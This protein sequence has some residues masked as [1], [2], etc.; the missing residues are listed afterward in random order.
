M[1]GVD[2]YQA[3]PDD[4]EH[5]NTPATRR[6]R[7]GHRRRQRPDLP[8]RPL[9]RRGDD[10]HAHGDL[11]R[12][13]R[14]PLRLLGRRRLRG[15]R[16]GQLLGLRPDATSTTRS[17][18]TATRATPGTQPFRSDA[19]G[20]GGHKW[21]VDDAG[22]ATHTG[23]GGSYI[24]DVRDPLHPREVANTGAAGDSA[25]EGSVNHY[26]DFIH[27]NSFRP[28]APGV[29]R[30]CAPV[31]GQRQHP[32]RHR[33]GLRGPRLLDRRVVPDLARQA[34]RRL[35]RLD[36]AAGQ[37]GARRPRHLPGPG[38]ARSAPR[39]G[40]TTTP[41]ASSRSASTAAAPS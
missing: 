30:R 25:R 3:S 37:G 19:V 38:R 41:A 29:P 23:A 5:V 34:P 13:H 7:A 2:L 10:Q 31:A 20:W 32:A 39:T 16:P 14:L 33:G 9:A 15:R 24:Y 6:L 11:H 8:A 1:I 40:S 26:N 35:G 4:L 17:R 12:R 36:R 18:S 22:Y 21:N 27:H 28:N